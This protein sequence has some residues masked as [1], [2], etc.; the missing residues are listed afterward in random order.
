MIRKKSHDSVLLSTDE[1]TWLENDER[2]KFGKSPHDAIQERLDAC[3]RAI[4]H[5]KRVILEFETRISILRQIIKQNCEHGGTTLFSICPM[6]EMM[7]GIAVK[8]C[9]NCGFTKVKHLLK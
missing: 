2:L 9:S 3:E 6:C 1:I 4:E 7:F 5:S 8:N